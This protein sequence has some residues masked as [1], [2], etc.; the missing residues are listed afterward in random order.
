MTLT[1]K[2]LTDGHEPMSHAEVDCLKELA[3]TLPLHPLIVNIGADVGVST[4]AF[5]EARPDCIIF[6]IDVLPCEQELEHVRQGGHTGRRVI[7]VLGDSKEIG[8]AFPYQADLLF[9]D[10]DHWG[11][12][13]DIEAWVYTGKV[14]PDGIVAFHDY[15][16]PPN[17]ENNPG[18]VYDDVNRWADSHPEYRQIAWVDRV[19]AF[20]VPA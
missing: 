15:I 8:P 1:A 16:V 13:K 19:I 7:R 20:R 9:I 17:P 14:K 2:D 10:G 5:L 12:G 3:D 6:S 18:C 4:L 11:A